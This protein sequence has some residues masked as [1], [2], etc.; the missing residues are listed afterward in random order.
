MSYRRVTIIYLLQLIFRTP[1]FAQDL[2]PRAYARVPVNLTTLVTGFSY[3]YG[4][5]VTD[6]TL[7]VK[8]IKADAETP[9]IGIAH[10]FN[11][12]KLTSQVL[13]AVPY[14]WAQ[15]SGDVG[16]QSR[17]ITRNGFSDI[18]LR[19]SVLVV[20]APAASMAEL[21]K[22]PRKTILGISLNAV[23]P[24]GQFYPDK[25]I[26]LGTN[27]YSLRP[28]IALSQPVMQRW[29]LD[30]YAGVWFFTDNNSYYPGDAVR[31]QE[32]MGAFQAHLS[33]NISALMWVALDGTYY[34]GGTS[35]INDI[36]ND[37]RQ[38]NTRI[39]ATTVIPLSKRSA[40][41][42]SYSTGAIVRA[43]QDF[44]SYSI[45]WQTSWMKKVPKEVISK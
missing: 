39:G 30:I 7:P 25:L 5:V 37:D 2:D 28:E 6:V 27:R 35:S 18:R 13:V 11:F 29:L 8:N 36:S 20:G 23:L 21:T 45:G 26:N 17:S 3:A 10:S 9:S 12:F 33:Y 16:G 24:T 34:V 4:G 40:I 31:S 32:P 22:S 19:F 15:V 38:A 1:S 42:F 43:G 14:T 44:D 41:K